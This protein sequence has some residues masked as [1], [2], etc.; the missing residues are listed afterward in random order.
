MLSEIWYPGWRAT[1]NGE[2]VPILRTNGALRGIAVPAGTSQVE[3]EFSPDSWRAGLLAAVAG[4]V[5]LIII[6]I[7]EKTPKRQRANSSE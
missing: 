5:L 2:P 7:F 6:F 4:W 3:M 1:V